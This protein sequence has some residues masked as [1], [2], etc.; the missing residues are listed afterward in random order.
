MLR[1][2][3]RHSEN[4]KNLLLIFPLHQLPL[5]NLLPLLSS[6]DVPVQA[7]L[8]QSHA[9][10]TSQKSHASIEEVTSGKI[11]QCRTQLIVRDKEK[12]NP[13]PDF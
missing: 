12:V 6:H 9:L 2:P 4:L 13:S 3:I 8:V 7:S 1:R 11:D 10:L 5:G